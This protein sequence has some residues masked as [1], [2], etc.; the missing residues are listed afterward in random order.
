MKT[1]IILLG[2]ALICLLCFFVVW[3]ITSILEG[4]SNSQTTEDMKDDDDFYWGTP[5]EG[6]NP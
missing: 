6:P 5:G 2:I 4:H 3:I 1:I